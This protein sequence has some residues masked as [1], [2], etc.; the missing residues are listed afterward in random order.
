MIAHR[1][2]KQKTD[3]LHIPSKYSYENMMKRH[4][5]KHASI[6]FR[7]DLLKSQARAMYQNEYDSVNSILNNHL[8][9]NTHTDYERLVNRR[10]VLKK[11]AER[12]LY[13]HDVE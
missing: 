2:P 5:L 11:L 10:S 7:N 6:Q 1:R 8:L 12:A 4:T 9:N 3:P 13:N